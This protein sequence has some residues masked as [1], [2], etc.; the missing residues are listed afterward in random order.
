[1]IR[2]P[3]KKDD[4]WL[5]QLSARCTAPQSRPRPV[6]FAFKFMEATFTPQAG[7]PHIV[8]VYASPERPFPLGILHDRKCMTLTTE[9]VD[10][11]SAPEHLREAIERQNREWCFLRPGETC[12][13]GW[14]AAYFSICEA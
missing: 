5:D 1:M 10:P 3:D 11:D 14:S 4:D 8:G 12:E 6:E 9:A 7:R 13:H 2:I